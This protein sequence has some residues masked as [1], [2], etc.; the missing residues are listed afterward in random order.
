MQTSSYSFPRQCC[1]CLGTPSGSVKVESRWQDGSLMRTFSVDV[2]VCAECQRREKRKIFVLL[3][4]GLGAA[5]VGAALFGLW[6]GPKGILPGAGVFGATYVWG[7]IGLANSPL[8]LA[9]F[10]QH[11]RLTF[12]NKDY[13][14]S[15]RAA[16]PDSTAS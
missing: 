16:N 6:L 8:Q 4:L 11:G 10:D 7:M 13:E 1:G 14:R 3:G 12:K 2:P 5:A 15:F 9:A